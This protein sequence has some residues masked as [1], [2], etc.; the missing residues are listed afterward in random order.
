M[1]TN[2][3]PSI[4]PDPGVNRSGRAL[5]SVG[6]CALH[7]QFPSPRSAAMNAIIDATLSTPFH[8]NDHVC[9]EGFL[10]QTRR[11]RRAY[12]SEVCKERATTSGP[13]RTAAQR[14]AP[15][16]GSGFVAPRGMLPR[17]AWPEPKSDATNV[18]VFMKR[19]T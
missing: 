15:L 3:P 6:V 8:K 16:F 11:E 5:L 2:R 18:V 7:A 1:N 4:G 10:A 14:V 19:S 9:G 13:K 12:P 17:C